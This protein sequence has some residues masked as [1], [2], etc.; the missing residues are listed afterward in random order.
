MSV[1]SL[2]TAFVRTETELLIINRL[3]LGISEGGLLTST[4]VL[5]TRLVHEDRTRTGECRI[6]AELGC[7]VPGSSA[8]IGFDSVV[9]KLA[10][11]VRAR[12]D[13]RIRLGFRLD[14]GYSR[15][16]R[17]GKVA[18]SVRARTD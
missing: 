2:T 7:R 18:Q 10:L 14:L 17:Q 13:S 4:L 12:S 6:S 16:A 5:D 8:D 1:V 9:R 3:V 11:D 15:D